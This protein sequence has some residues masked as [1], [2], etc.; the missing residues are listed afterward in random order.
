MSKRHSTKRLL[1][2]ILYVLFVAYIGADRMVLVPIFIYRGLF[3]TLRSATRVGA[4]GF[5]EII[6]IKEVGLSSFPD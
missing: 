5:A 6:R 3:Q 4:L 2:Y 1:L